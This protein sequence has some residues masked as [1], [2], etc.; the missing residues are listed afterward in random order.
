MAERTFIANNRRI[1]SLARARLSATRVK[2]PSVRVCKRTPPPCQWPRCDWA[3]DAPRWRHVQSLSSTMR[4]AIVA[5]AARRLVPFYRWCWPWAPLCDAR[6]LNESVDALAAVARGTKWED[7]DGRRSLYYGAEAAQFSA[8]GFG[9]AD[10]DDSL[11]NRQHAFAPEAWK[12]GRVARVVVSAIAMIWFGKPRRDWEKCMYPGQQALSEDPAWRTAWTR[13]LWLDV[14]K[15]KV[16]TRADGQR[17]A[18]DPD[19]FG[20]LWPEGKPADW[21]PE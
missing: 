17:L 1:A 21:P 8:E 18:C 20:P 19:G 9:S 3:K 10:G 16:M 14:A 5:R 15:A 7:A 2:P 12:A 4:L 13:A 6:A 11:D